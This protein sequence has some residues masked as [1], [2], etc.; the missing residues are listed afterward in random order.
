MSRGD[1]AALGVLV[2]RYWP[3]LVRY[4]RGVVGHHDDA[5]DVA[6]RTFER[7]WERRDA[8]RVDGSALPLLLRITK[9]SSLDTLRRCSARDRANQ[10]APIPF[11]PPSPDH[12][13]EEDEL[14]ALV[15]AAIDSLPERRREILILTR[16]QGL[17]RMEIADLLDLAPQTV[18]NHLRLA[19]QDL[20]AKL[21]PHFGDPAGSAVDEDVDRTA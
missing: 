15:N 6:Q 5:A 19:M 18:A 7:V 10:N 14:K 9:N 4:A 3:T 8:W 13:L 1:A 17:S 2:E 16:F 12:M 21:A 11:S 20:R